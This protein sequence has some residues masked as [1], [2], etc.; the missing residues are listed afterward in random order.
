MA[1][2][3]RHSSTEAGWVVPAPRD[4]RDDD[5]QRTGQLPGQL[6]LGIGGTGRSRGWRE[7]PGVP[8]EVERPSGE[9]GEGKGRPLSLP[10]DD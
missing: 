2:V 3:R 6:S 5:P 10:R 9:R 1:A 8:G 7:D 4:E